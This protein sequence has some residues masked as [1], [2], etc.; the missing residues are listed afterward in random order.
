MVSYF[1]ISGA[2]APTSLGNNVKTQPCPKN[3]IASRAVPQGYE[4]NATKLA[5][6]Q[7]QPESTERRK[8]IHQTEKQ[9]TTSAAAIEAT[10]TTPGR[11]LSPKE[12]A[13]AR[14]QGSPITIANDNGEGFESL[15]A[16]GRAR[17]ALRRR[18]S[19]KRRIAPR[20]VAIKSI[21]KVDAAANAIGVI[22]AGDY[23]ERA[24]R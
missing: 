20:C 23:F 8:Y 17:I 11:D 10:I 19:S 24:A 15:P 14:P 18:V 9:R 12:S 13:P 4:Y 1:R 6:S 22:S 7:C 2:N 3:P 16:S 5:C 21:V